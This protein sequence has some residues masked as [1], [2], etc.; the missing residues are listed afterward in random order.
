MGDTSGVNLK[1]NYCSKEIQERPLPYDQCSTPEPP[2]TPPGEHYRHL[3]FFA[4]SDYNFQ[5]QNFKRLGLGILFRPFDKGTTGLWGF[6][7]QWE[8]NFDNQWTALG[9]IQTSFNLQRYGRDRLTVAALGGLR[10]ES[11]GK[12][13]GQ[14]GLE[15][16]L[17]WRVLDKGLLH[18]TVNFPVVSARYTVGSSIADKASEDSLW[19]ML[20]GIRGSYDMFPSGQ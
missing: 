7:A 15:T 5:A 9:R 19:T 1:L 11:D 6:G 12:N 20:L 16:S 14:V 17:E 10:H 13:G 2:W 3:S 8:T 18:F 4:D